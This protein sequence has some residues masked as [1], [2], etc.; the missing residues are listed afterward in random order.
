[1]YDKGYTRLGNNES[2]VL[3]INSLKK[4]SRNKVTFDMFKVS[5]NDDGNMLCVEFSGE[6]ISV[7]E[8]LISRYLDILPEKCRKEIVESD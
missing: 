1:M 5:V 6:D 8:G 7:G 3:D 2:I 4:P